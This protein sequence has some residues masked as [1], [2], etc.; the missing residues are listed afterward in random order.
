MGADV[1]R[2]QFCAQPP[3]RNLKF[4]FGPAHEIRRKLL[5]LWNS[6]SFWVEYAN[7]ADFSPVTDDLDEGPPVTRLL[8]RWMLAR[9]HQLVAEANAGYEATLT[10]NVIVAFESFVEDLS[11][12]YIRRSR[13]SFWDGESDAL[14]TLWY[15]LMTSLR[16]IA[17]VMP[18]LTDHL[19]RNLSG[20]DDASSIHLA[21]WPSP[22]AP[23]LELLEEIAELRR[24][25]ELGRQARSASGI[26]LRQPLRRVVV[27]GASIA[28][29][30]ADE[31]AGELN[32]DQVEFGRVDASELRVKPNLKL[33]GPKL[34]AALAQVRAAL[35]EGSFTEL[36]GGRFEVDGQ[37]LE[38][39]EVL[40][41]RVGRE[42]WVV[43]S[44]GRVTVALE[45]TLDD[46]LRLKGRLNDLIRAIQT[47][48]KDSGLAVIDRIRLV[49]PEADPDLLVFSERIARE[50]LAVEISTGPAL[51]LEKA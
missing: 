41:E 47:L 22:P 4:G 31:I 48:R 44:D 20:D 16:V 21:G 39:A 8:D 33:L 11:N 24:V 46:E 7:I 15:A 34:G 3:D 30:H 29:S 2:W 32:V 9:T 43:Q 42:G 23:D 28:A 12:W 13:Q 51:K 1:V 6:A 14:R 49:I 18:F 27:H 19:W 38:P 40:V 50:T 36:A 17:P 10:A 35:A 45:T 26:R 5:T 25:V 37:V